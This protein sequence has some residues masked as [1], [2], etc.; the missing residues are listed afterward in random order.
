MI[1][2]PMVLLLVLAGCIGMVSVQ[3]AQPAM[4]ELLKQVRQ[5]RVEMVEEQRQRE[6][7]FLDEQTMQQERLEQASS[8]LKA[9]QQ[10][11]ARLRETFDHNE[12]RLAALNSELREG[13]GELL[14]L[15]SFAKQLAG[16]TQAVFQNSLITTQFP[17]R[18]ALL[19]K[20]S[21]KSLPLSIV[22]LEDLWFTL[23]QEMTESGKVAS[24]L[25]PVIGADGKPR[26][27]KVVRVGAFNAVSEGRFLQLL[28]ESGALEE[29][30]R[31]PPYGQRKLA[32][33][34][35][36]ANGTV[37]P[38]L[39][40]PSRG[41]VLALLT[42]APDL[43]E[44]IR[45]GKAVGYVIIA[46]ALI[47]VLLALERVIYLSYIGKR[48]KWQLTNET[49]D[50][51]NPLGRVMAVF[52]ENPRVDTDTLEL[53]IDETIL[54]NIP[55]LRR[56]L[57]ALKIL[58]AVAPLLGLLGT[59]VGLIET[60]QS[61]TLFGTGDPKLM[62][63]GISQALVTTVL[64]LCAAIPLILMHS[65]LS[66]KSRR[67]VSIL[68]EQSAGIVARHAEQRGQHAAMA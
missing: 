40:D 51:N 44:R 50:S 47:G 31:Q 34:L 49:A 46:L 27:R 56:G 59:V 54:K 39:I 26:E 7:R 62:A 60:F 37:Q 28:P 68:E 29:L 13:A 12:A 32:S 58:A 20:L 10:R 38:M 6:R 4:D 9:E 41:S 14:E 30:S 24:Y 55:R 67:L 1:C 23:L 22:D 18:L 65:G 36:A 61:I 8:E 43:L 19:Q 15:F 57:S 63:G 66:S 52:Q 45:Q 3:A 64:G 21:G 53:M 11:N 5:A 42:Q 35:E 2:K 17:E 25:S 33:G 48:M 16:D